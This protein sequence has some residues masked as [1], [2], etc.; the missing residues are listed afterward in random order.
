MDP[1]ENKKSHPIIRGIKV[2]WTQ[3]MNG[4]HNDSEEFKSLIDHVINALEQIEQ[5]EQMLEA[6]EQIDSSV[7]GE[8]IPSALDMI[9]SAYHKHQDRN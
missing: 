2:Q 6:L 4:W 7:N 1:D 8:E 3:P 9:M 5:E